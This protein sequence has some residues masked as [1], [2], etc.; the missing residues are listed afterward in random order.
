[1]D[2]KRS[3]RGQCLWRRGLLI[4]L[5]LLAHDLLMASVATGSAPSPGPT[6]ILA[7]MSHQADDLGAAAHDHESF[8]GHPSPCGA[9]SEA[10]AAADPYRE[11][12]GPS[13]SAA[14]F[15]IDVSE[16][17][18]PLANRWSAPLWPPGTL[19]AWLQVYRI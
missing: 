10:V 14:L 11:T 16:A 3:Q 2:P 12:A 6:Y 9:T 17:T 8:P 4:A 1:M 13:V 18:T 5:A 7:S 15:T 19:R